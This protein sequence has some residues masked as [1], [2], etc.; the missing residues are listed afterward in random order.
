MIFIDLEQIGK[1][2]LIHFV[3]STTRLWRTKKNDDEEQRRTKSSTMV[4]PL[5]FNLQEGD[6]KQIQWWRTEKQ[7]EDSEKNNKQKKIEILIWG[8][9]GNLWTPT[10]FFFKTWLLTIKV[11]YVVKNE[12]SM[13]RVV[14]FSNFHL[15]A[16]VCFCLFCLFLVLHMHQCKFRGV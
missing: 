4:R 1:V 14:I 2:F 10:E 13:F 3:K 11:L 5:V 12:F 7:E 9:L 16:L 8:H 6:E 15:R